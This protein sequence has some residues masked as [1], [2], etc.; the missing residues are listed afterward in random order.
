[1]ALIADVIVGDA[2]GMH[3]RGANQCMPKLVNMTE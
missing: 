1:M 2:A 3:K